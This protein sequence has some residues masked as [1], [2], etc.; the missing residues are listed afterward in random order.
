MIQYLIGDATQPLVDGPKIIV[1]I[2]NNIGAWGKGFVLALS[3]RWTKPEAE[4]RQWHKTGRPI[5]FELGNVQF[6]SVK[7]NLWVA[8]LIG[9]K[10]IRPMGSLEPIRYL[11]VR[12]GLFLVADFAREHRATVHM[13]RIGCGLAGGTWDRVE[14]I[15]IKTLV[16][17][18]IEVFVYDL[19]DS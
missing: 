9:Q 15:I 14:P 13:P 8:N 6:V 7:N 5:L 12:K 2:C 1:H 16:E 3:A 17:K 10:G 4:Y 18:G 19:P 11:S